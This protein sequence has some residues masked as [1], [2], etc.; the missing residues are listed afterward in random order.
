MGLVT[1]GQGDAEM[2]IRPAYL[3]PVNM[4][5]YRRSDNELGRVTGL[6]LC[7]PDEDLKERPV[8]QV[9]WTD[10]KVDYVTL[11]A[12]HAGVVRI[13]SGDEQKEGRVN[14]SKAEEIADLLEKYKLVRDEL[15]TWKGYSDDKKMDFFYVTHTAGCVSEQ[16]RIRCLGLADIGR[17]LENKVGDFAEALMMVGV[18]VF[19]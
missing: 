15:E 8:V 18:D 11:D 13:E 10:G 5:V 3:S 12:I 9:L 19:L 2:K 17:A 6:Y 16:K 1:V 14:L 4:S 7:K